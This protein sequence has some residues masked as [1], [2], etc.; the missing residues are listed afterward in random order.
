MQPLGVLQHEG[1]SGAH[2]FDD[3]DEASQDP[4]GDERAGQADYHDPAHA[5]RY[6]SVGSPHADGF[7]RNSGALLRSRQLI[8]ALEG[9]GTSAGGHSQVTRPMPH[10]QHF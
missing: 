7:K 2:G 6:R 8:G 4:V 10:R 9:C 3:L 1:V 5:E